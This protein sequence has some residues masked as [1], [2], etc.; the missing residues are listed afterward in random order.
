MV[1][2]EGCTSWRS[3]LTGPTISPPCSVQVYT[4]LVELSAHQLLALPE[5]GQKLNPAGMAFTSQIAGVIV[6]ISQL[7][8]AARISTSTPVDATSPAL[9]IL[10]AREGYAQVTEF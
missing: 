9:Q 6:H 8:L 5:S 2:A 3:A 7:C 1:S 4:T 10:P